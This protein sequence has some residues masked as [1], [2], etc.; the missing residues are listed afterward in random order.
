MAEASSARAAF[1]VGQGGRAVELDQHVARLHQ[2]AVADA[3][4]LDPTGLQRLDDL[5]LSHRLKLALRG[6]DD[7]DAAEIGP[8][9]RG[10]DEGADDP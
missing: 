10:D 1:R 7:V 4:V 8:G 5:D 9:E 2:R 3:N 6:G